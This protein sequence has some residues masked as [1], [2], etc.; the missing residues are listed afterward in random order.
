MAASVESME[1]CN[2][3]SQQLRKDEDETTAAAQKKM[4]RGAAKRKR[5]RRNKAA[6]KHKKTRRMSWISG[7][8]II[9]QII[10]M[11]FSSITTLIVTLAIIHQNVDGSIDGNDSPA[12]PPTTSRSTSLRHRQMQR[13]DRQSSYANND[14][15]STPP[16]IITDPSI[17]P[18]TKV[19]DE[20][21]LIMIPFTTNQ[22]TISL[23]TQ[24]P[25]DSTLQQICLDTPN[26][27][28]EWGGGCDIYE[29]EPEGCPLTG[30]D[31]IGIM[32]PATENCCHCGGGSITLP[33]TISR[34]P[35]ASPTL[36]AA[37]SISTE[38][39]VP[40]SLSAN[41]T[42]LC[43][44]TPDWKDGLGQECDSYK[45]TSE[46]GCFWNGALFIGDMGS[47]NEHCCYCNGGIRT[48]S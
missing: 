20:A 36:S 6:A 8:G 30:N 40:P 21:S 41:P 42:E 44:D 23:P 45:E 14:V 43:L 25:T 27:T 18:S 17:A 38:P 34:Q 22:P 29:W 28:N 13:S 24:V 16:I 31:A 19:E 5:N 37:P 33:P 10:V 39:S 7:A 12:L 2:Q 9:P 35:S 46:P 32:G 1:S 26:W 4:S 3:H 15:A 48:V 11:A 47:A